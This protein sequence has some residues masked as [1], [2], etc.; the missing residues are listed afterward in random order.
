MAFS[1]KTAAWRRAVLKGCPLDT[2]YS[3]T[4]GGKSWL[5]ANHKSWRRT[6]SKVPMRLDVLQRIMVLIQPDQPAA[7]PVNGPS[8]FCSR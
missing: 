4:K 3:F 5:I 1:G 6:A 7:N 2:G 8:N